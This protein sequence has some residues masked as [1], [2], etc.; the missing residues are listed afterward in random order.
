MFYFVHP[1]RHATPIP[2]KCAYVKC[3]ASEISFGQTNS[4]KPE[5]SA[6]DI[7]PSL[8]VTKLLFS[9]VHAI[10]ATPTRF[11]AKDLQSTAP[12][13]DYLI[14]PPNPHLVSVLFI[15]H[16]ITEAGDTIV[17]ISW[18]AKHA[19]TGLGWNF[20]LEHCHLQGSFRS[21]PLERNLSITLPTFDEPTPLWLT[22]HLA[23]AVK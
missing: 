15:P 6:V 19:T 3:N 9:S 18:N 8:T 14:L 21:A 4:I 5:Q 7:A 23:V 20:L 22:A 2:S 16:S 13:F 11:T 10:H 17:R 12:N 1:T